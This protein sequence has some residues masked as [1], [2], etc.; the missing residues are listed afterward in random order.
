[1][2]SV[3]LMTSCGKP[4]VKDWNI[5]TNMNKMTETSI[6]TNDYSEDTTRRY[7]NV[8]TVNVDTDL[9]EIVADTEFIRSNAVL[10][11]DS[12]TRDMEIFSIGRHDMNVEKPERC[13]IPDCYP[14]VKLMNFKW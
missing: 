10:F 1:M 13:L 7:K 12:T 14:R 11:L 8:Y 2:L 3:L 5:I 9:Y 4:K 6:M